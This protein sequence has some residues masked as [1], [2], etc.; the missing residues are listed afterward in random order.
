VRDDPSWTT[1]SELA[2]YTFCPRA[3]FYRRHADAPRSPRAD[4]GEAFHR[5]QLAADR[6]REDHAGV[7]WAAVL[8]GVAL[9]AVA[10]LLLGP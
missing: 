4:A 6:W 1:P 2:E 8:A 7:L 3:A 9:L 10:V 5:R